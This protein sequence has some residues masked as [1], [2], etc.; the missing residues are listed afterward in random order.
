MERGGDRYMGISMEYYWKMERHNRI[1]KIDKIKMLGK[2]KT[3]AR[4]Q[5]NSRLRPLPNWYNAYALF[6]EPTSVRLFPPPFHHFICLFSFLFSSFF[7]PFKR[8][9]YFFSVKK[10]NGEQ[11]LE[12]SANGEHEKCEVAVKGRE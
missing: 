3:E 1:D 12:Y 4:S 2:G 7:F 6:F 5:D 10:Q 11:K 9:T 8:E